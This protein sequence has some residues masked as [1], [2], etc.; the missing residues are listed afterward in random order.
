METFTS[1]GGMNWWSM[2]AFIRDSPAPSSVAK[3]QQS[4]TATGHKHKKKKNASKTHIYTNV[5]TKQKLVTTT[6][7]EKLKD[8]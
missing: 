3:V 4:S 5:Y 7:K 8:P 6:T 2:E 1:A